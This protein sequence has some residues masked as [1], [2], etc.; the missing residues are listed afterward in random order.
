M[1]TRNASNRKKIDSLN[2]K[3][4]L[5]LLICLVL[6]LGG[7]IPGMT[8][9]ASATVFPDSLT[10]TQQT[11]VT[12][13]LASAAMMLRARMYESGNSDWASITEASIKSVA[14]DVYGSL[15]YS[16]TYTTNGNSMT[17]AHKEV[18]GMTVSQ[19]KSLLNEHP[20]GIV[21]YVRDVPHAVLVT[22]YIGDTFYCFEPANSSYYGRRPLS[23]TY[24]SSRAG[25]QDSILSKMDDYWYISSYPRKLVERNCEK[26][27]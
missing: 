11:S 24:L 10:L 25:N 23:N 26:Y 14:W 1:E 7:I 15:G 22:D 27:V 19:L 2:F 6:L 5:S 17:V 13:T 4:I 9:E 21:L 3:P 18:S 20:E 12:C 16:W 8:F